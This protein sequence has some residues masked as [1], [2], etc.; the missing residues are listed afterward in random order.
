MN[1]EITEEERE[2]LLRMCK[3]AELFAQMGMLKDVKAIDPRG[4]LH[5]IKALI[6]KLHK[7]KTQDL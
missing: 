5:K 7:C 1:I 4:D 3:R 6:D 2:F